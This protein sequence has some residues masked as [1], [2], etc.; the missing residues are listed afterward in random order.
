MKF[1]VTY[2]LTAA[3]PIALIS[4]IVVGSFT[5]I[6]AERRTRQDPERLAYEALIR[7]R[8]QLHALALPSQAAHAL[9]PLS[10]GGVMHF[11]GD[12]MAAREFAIVCLNAMKVDEGV[13]VFVRLDR[14]QI[15]AIRNDVVTTM[16]AREHPCRSFGPKL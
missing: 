16:M 11:R 5:T 3:V 7:D 8:N 14:G 9:S 4:M 6:R 12:D 2:L 10:R 1:N 15:T 13:P